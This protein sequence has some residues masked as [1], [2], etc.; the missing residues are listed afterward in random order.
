MG[1]SLQDQLNQK[2]PFMAIFHRRT[3]HVPPPP[4]FPPTVV[5]L[6]LQEELVGPSSSAHK[7]PWGERGCSH[8]PDPSLQEAVVWNKCG[9]PPSLTVNSMGDMK[10][11]LSPVLPLTEPSQ[12][13]SL[14]SCPMPHVC[15][16][17]REKWREGK[18]KQPVALLVTLSISDAALRISWAWLAASH[19]YYHGTHGTRSLGS[20]EACFG[21]WS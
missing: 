17:L 18:R 5:F 13:G 1:Y 6:F 19:C 3:S 11:E 14:H 4:A 7:C 2:S 10:M 9:S 20:K 21:S 12:E 8:T 15:T 16:S